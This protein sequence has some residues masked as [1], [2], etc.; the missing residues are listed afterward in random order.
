MKSRM[1]VVFLLLV[2]SVVAQLEAGSIIQ[3]VRVR[4]NFTNGICDLSAHVRLMGRSGPVAEAIPNDQCEAEFLN[5]P[6]GTYHLNVSGQNVADTDNVIMPS[7]G[8]TDFEVKVKRANELDRAGGAPG[9]PIVSAADLGIPTNAQKEFDKANELIT[10][11]DFPKAI[12]TLNRAIAIYPAYAGA[13]N[14]LGVIYARLGDRAHERDALQKAITINDHFAPAYVNLGRM[15]IATNDF[16][17]A[18]TALNKATSY[19]PTDA[20]TL[21]LLTY[22]QFMDRHLDEAIATSRKA[23]TLAGA[24]AFV[25]QVAAR[26]YEQKRDGANA[27]AQLELFLNEEPSGAR[28]DIARKE[29]A[30][31]HA[32]VH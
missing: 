30:A 7:V 24:H 11:Q 22:S 27:I 23:H 15:S 25:H 16:P 26:A 2:G 18:E 32:I 3:R 31:L 29:L 19:D 6:V 28:A 1:C 20:M 13:Y 17:S 12:Q 8:T 21:V 4:V 10:R 9:G 14:N 5:V